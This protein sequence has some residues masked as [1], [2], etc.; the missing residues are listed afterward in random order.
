MSAYIIVQVSVN[1]P[2]EYEIYKSLTPSSIH[3]YGG[4]FVVRGA[5]VETLEGSWQPERLV[6]LE[7]PDRETAKAWWNSEEYA[8]AK[9]IRQRTAD[10]EMI[11]VEGYM[12][13]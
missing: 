5:A 4:R 12:L 2:V 9:A 13:V 8:P 1:E 11:L 10:T 7:F 3:T 6:V